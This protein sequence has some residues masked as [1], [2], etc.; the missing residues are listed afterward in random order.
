M[1]LTT[2]QILQFSVALLMAI[3]IFVAA[4]SAPRHVSIGILIAL[5]PFQVIETKYGSSSI[6]LTYVVV[7]ALMLGRDKL[8]VPLLGAM[9]AVLFAYALSISQVHKSI[10]LQHGI[11]VFFLVSGFAMFVLAYNLARDT[12]DA[13]KL[14][15]I[16]IV[17]NCLVAVYCLLQLSAGAGAKTTWFGISELAM[18]RNRGEHDP[19]LVGPF[20]APGITSEYLLL[21]N[22]ILA[23]D[24]IHAVGRRKWLVIALLAMNVGFMIATANRGSFLTLIAIFPLF[25]FTFRRLLG[26]AR[27]LQF[28]VTGA[29]LVACA[30]IVT[31][32]YSDFGTLFDRLDDVEIEGGIPDTRKVA[33]PTAWENIVQRPWLGHGPRLRLIDDYATPYPGHVVIHYPH[34]LYLFLLFTVGIVGTAA[35][36]AFIFRVWYRLYRA[37]AVAEHETDSYLKGLVL[38]GPLLLLT[39][40][41]DQIKI[42]FL[43]IEFADYF[44][45]IFVIMGIWMGLGDRVA[46]KVPIEAATPLAAPLGRQGPRPRLHSPRLNKRLPLR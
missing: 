22:L 28:S 3:G 21:M 13:R 29:L 35:M 7:A 41:I 44:Q 36:L 30:A 34:D 27:V 37:K 9:L 20:S 42:E 11:Y 2:A 40:L 26:F 17:M 5:L 8:R 16:L 19:R 1:D 39:L 12:E 10:Y 45:F 14:I 25:L 43:R 31:I 23:Y 24:L 6:M 32:T 33:W 15:N 46:S 4:Y 18:N 38:L